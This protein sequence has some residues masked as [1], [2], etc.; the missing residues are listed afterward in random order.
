MPNTAMTN[1]A[2]V[3]TS[4]DDLLT[5][6]IGYFEDFEEQSR[7]SRELMERDRDYADHKQWTDDELSALRKR[8]QPPTVNNRVRK[9]VNFLRGLERQS[10]TDPKAYPRTPQH[11]EDADAATDALRY[12]ADNT[13]LDKERS[14]FYDNFLVEGVGGAEVIITKHEKKGVTVREIECNQVSVDRLFWDYHSRRLDF[15]D[16]RYMGIIIWQDLD[17]AQAQ[18]PTKKDLLESSFSSAV[19]DTYEDKPV[20]WVDSA[21]KRVRIAQIY[22][23]HNGEWHYGI[24]TKAGW[25]VEAAPSVYLD[26]DGKP[27]NAIKMQSAYVDREGN[28]FGEV[29]FMI[30]Q[31]DAVNKRESKMLHLLSQRQTYGNDK[32][33][34][35][36]TR[37]AKAEL[38]K[39]DGHVKLNGQTKFGEDFGILPT[40]DMANGQFTLLQE[41]KEEIDQTSVNASLTGS[42]DKALSGRAILAQQSGGQMEITHLQDGKREWEHRIY[43]S[44]WNRVKQ[45]WTDEKWI[46]VTDDDQ[47][48]RFVG[49]NRK[50]TVRDKLEDEGQEI[51]PEF[52]NDPR[53][54]MDAGTQNNIS[55]LDIDIIL[56]DAP[57]T[58]TIQQEQFEMLTTMYQA[59]PQ[60]IS[61]D[62]LIEASQLKGKDKILEKMR[63]GGEEEQAAFAAEQQQNKD[64]I[65]EGELA[66]IE[67]DKANAA[68]LNA[69]AGA[70]PQRDAI[71][72][73]TDLEVADINAESKENV[74]IMNRNTDVI[75]DKMA[76]QN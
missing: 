71:K 26:E 8:G 44:F 17:E 72:A 6:V 13:R 51:P 3:A 62:L 37:E 67:V 57:D 75:G 16:S 46:R 24:Y 56:A 65:R 42:N 33:L 31:Q 59:N 63:G 68:K 7:T 66:K 40:G 54:D 38:A 35:D 69:E 76:A 32:A 29:R 73:Q 58:V 61:F 74:A 20:K 30:E 41:A 48:V 27:E 70:I 60:A 39:P 10:R 11:E 64:I 1:D 53:L 52:A 5:T 55:V 47:N 18:F 19:D 9:K 36:G 14:A 45:F 22:F 4:S 50:M 28:R 21:R 43:T 12:V 23:K 25:L 15:E 49:L 34:P 2:D